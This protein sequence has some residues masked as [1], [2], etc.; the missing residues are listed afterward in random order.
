MVALV[1]SV[2]DVS[3]NS[4]HYSEECTP[5]IRNHFIP[6]RQES[7]KQETWDIQNFKLHCEVKQEC[8]ESI[9]WFCKLYQRYEK[10]KECTS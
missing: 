10:G 1:G 5:V 9:C 2:E 4:N 3:Q 7:W 6:E 8:H